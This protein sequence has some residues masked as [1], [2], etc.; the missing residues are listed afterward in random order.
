MDVRGAILISLIQHV[1][2][3]FGQGGFAK[4]LNLVTPE[5]RL[6]LLSEID[7][8]G[9]YPLKTAMIEPMSNM[10]QAFYNW[11]LKKAAW[12]FGRFSAEY[13]FKG[14]KRLLLKLPSANY[15]VA[16]AGEF[17][18]SY[19]RPCTIEV[20]ENDEKRAVVRITE[21]PEM[22]KTTEFRIAG[23]IERGLELNGCKD[24]QVEIRK[25]L[26]NFDRFT[27]YVIRWA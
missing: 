17:L 21:F 15:F 6:I 2:Q 18:P 8:E 5:A 3:E 7:E 13:R 11:D 14:L 16:K 4:W 25:S 24:I 22:D 9:W 26:T 1:R 27:E 10:A 20:P 23:W 12:L 19:Y